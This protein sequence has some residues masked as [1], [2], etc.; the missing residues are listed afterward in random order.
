MGAVGLLGL[1]LVAESQFACGSLDG[2]R[3]IL[4]LPSFLCW[5][6]TVSIVEVQRRA[7]VGE[8]GGR[9]APVE[10]EVEEDTESGRELA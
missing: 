2:K 6:V 4:H 3:G 1:A 5:Q 7:R 9:V 10:H 8:D